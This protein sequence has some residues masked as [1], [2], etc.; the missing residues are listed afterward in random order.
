MALM[1]SD[2][3]ATS[4]SWCLKAATALSLCFHTDDSQLHVQQGQPASADAVAAPDGGAALATGGALLQE[5]I[6]RVS[7]AADRV[8]GAGGAL[9]AA[10]AV[11][12]QMPDADAAASAKAF[13]AS[14]DAAARCFGAFIV[15]RLAVTV[16]ASVMCLRVTVRCD[17]TAAHVHDSIRLGSEHSVRRVQDDMDDDMHTERPHGDSPSEPRKDLKFE[18]QIYRVR[19]QMYLLDVQRL[20]GH[21]YLFLDLCAELISQLHLDAPPAPAQRESAPQPNGSDFMS[22]H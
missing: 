20:E 1:W 12:I 13:G 6:E 19:T 2:R 22:Q 5:R 15:V 18:V 7:G 8:C 3:L 10:R 11:Y 14:P 9:E 17:P 16:N 4:A 21:L